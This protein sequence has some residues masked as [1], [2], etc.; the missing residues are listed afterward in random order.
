MKLILTI[1]ICLG[2]AFFGQQVVGDIPVANWICGALAGLVS[3][4]IWLV[5]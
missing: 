5:N 4:A 3:M 1:T 2:S